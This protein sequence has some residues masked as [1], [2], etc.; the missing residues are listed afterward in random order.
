[1]SVPDPE[2]L[3]RLSGYLWR[4]LAE[5]VSFH[6]RS[7]DNTY[8]PKPS[9]RPQARLSGDGHAFSQSNGLASGDT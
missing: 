4:S 2:F 1:M 7:Q 5:P 8:Y 3:Q 6:T 9:Y